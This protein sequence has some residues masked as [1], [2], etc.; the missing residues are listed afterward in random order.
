MSI[1]VRL[2]ATFRELFGFKETDVAPDAAPTLGA[3][4]DR[5]ADTPERRL[6]LR[7]G[8]GLQPHVVVMVNGAPAPPQGFAAIPLKD[9]DVVAVFPLMG[10]G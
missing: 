6:A 3:L 10:G 7:E 4:F 8:A 5:L 9:G 1:R 2:F